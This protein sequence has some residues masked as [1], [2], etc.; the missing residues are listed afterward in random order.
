MSLKF[1]IVLFAISRLVECSLPYYG[2]TVGITPYSRPV[3]SQYHRQDNHGQYVYGYATEHS[4]QDE[5]K[6]ADGVTR[7]GYSYIDANGILQT[8]Q[9]ISD[10]VN[11]F[12]VLATNLPRDVPA[13]AHARAEH[14][15]QVENIKAEHAIIA[16]NNYAKH[17]H[18]E[19]PAALSPVPATGS[20]VVSVRT[21]EIVATPIFQPIV[22]A[23]DSPVP[24]PTGPIA[25]VIPVAHGHAASYV[26]ATISV[27]SQ[28]Q[29]QDALGQ[30][31]YGYADPLSA[32]TETK[33]AD[34]ITRGGYSYIDAN[35]IL[36][37]VQYVSDPVNGFR[38]KASNL[39]QAPSV[40]LIGPKVSTTVVGPKEPTAVIVP[41][42]EQKPI[43]VPT[44]IVP[45]ANLPVA[46]PEGA[47]LHPNPNHEPPVIYSDP[48]LTAPFYPQTVPPQY[49]NT[50]GLP[51]IPVTH[52]QA[53]LHN[54]ES[55]I[56]PGTENQAH[57]VSQQPTHLQEHQV[58]VEQDPNLQAYHE[59]QQ[60][61]YEQQIAHDQHLHQAQQ[62][63]H[64][65]QIQQAILNHGNE[66]YYN[67]QDPNLQQIILQHQNNPYHGHVQT[68]YDPNLQQVSH[69]HA[70]HEGH[71]GPQQVLVAPELHNYQH[72]QTPAQYS[73]VVQPGHA[74]G[75][76]H[77]PQ[78]LANG[79]A[80]N[81][82]EGVVSSHGQ[83]G[84]GAVAP[85]EHYVHG[86][87]FAAP[88]LADHNQHHTAHQIPL[89][90]GP[91]SQQPADYYAIDSGAINSVPINQQALNHAQS[92]PA[93]VRAD[94]GNSNA[95][96]FS[97]ANVGSDLF[98]PDG[99]ATAVQQVYQQQAP[100][101]HAAQV[102]AGHEQQQAFVL[103]AQA[104]HATQELHTSAGA[105]GK[106][107]TAPSGYYS[108]NI[109][110]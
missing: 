81:Q 26:P 73:Q 35:G 13:V 55:F 110:Y 75:H 93:Y 83:E 105:V 91:E 67:S 42:I 68:S 61:A 53:V 44:D 84:K 48:G 76:P 1:Q 57:I 4:S 96:K 28:Y 5:V 77:G 108:H 63:G 64:D 31:S 27:S 36:Q 16:A 38:V 97:L 18:Y 99:G 33:T 21:P 70:Q 86:E 104:G 82:Y 74:Y 87:I 20:Y 59:Q 71:F 11:G 47:Y 106:H 30:Y 98:V 54:K 17:Q 14:L 23:D 10:P 90:A 32:K 34:G 62:A 37:T 49:F 69:E 2:V 29:S 103:S 88:R 100:V 50:Q 58:Y 40:T 9:Y 52:S 25:A 56:A 95:E 41:A 60:I 12:R 39:P 65:S 94:D 8:V 45:N 92:Q 46:H 107:A 78:I 51:P 15:A 85:E 79:Y 80:Q 7:G 43:L 66:P 89:A 19:H 109:Q 24:L 102:A 6:T 22:V 3:V 101:E 72:E